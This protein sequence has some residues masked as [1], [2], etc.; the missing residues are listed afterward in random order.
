MEVCK[1]ECFYSKYY[2]KFPEFKQVIDSCIRNAHTEHKDELESL[3]S[4]NFQSFK[5]VTISTFQSI[6]KSS[7][8]RLLMTALAP[9]VLTPT[10]QIE[11]D[12]IEI[13]PIATPEA[14]SV[15]VITMTLV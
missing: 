11:S 13:T 7:K 1:K 15:S 6:P 10:L 9:R 8:F 2:Q 5:N 12:V 3:L 14:Q 4:R